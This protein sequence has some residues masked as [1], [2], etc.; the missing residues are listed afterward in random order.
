MAV[1]TLARNGRGVER[2]SRQSTRTLTLFRRRKY[3][4]TSCVDWT[5]RRGKLAIV[6]NARLTQQRYGKV[7]YSLRI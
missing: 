4:L 6:S 5:L 1:L 3:P 2:I 7:K